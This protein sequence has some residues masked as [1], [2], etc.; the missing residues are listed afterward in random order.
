MWQKAQ[1]LSFLKS[2]P[3]LVGAASLLAGGVGAT[4][5]YRVAH[6]RL[7]EKFKNLA[8]T[9]I[10]DA[11][12][13]YSQLNRV[14]S[15]YKPPTPQE[16]LAERMQDEATSAHLN[17]QGISVEAPA[18]SEEEL[19]VEETTV[20]VEHNVFTTQAD[21]LPAADSGW[22]YEA[23][24]ARRNGKRP[25]VISKDEFFEN[26]RD[27]T[28]SQLTYY[29]GDDI[30]ADGT[31]E[32]IEDVERVVG[33]D[34]LRRFGHGSGS[35]HIVYIRNDVMEEIFEIALSDGKF[36]HEVLNFI[37]HSDRQPLRKFR[38]YDD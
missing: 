29:A 25:Y 23:E 12:A 1:V 2:T 24:R 6:N 27:Y 5:G 9:E 36:A 18:E 3:V 20:T 8:E 22:D 13:Y 38:G 33:E 10:E 31:D 30:L 34:N 15:E 7:E 28:E 14:V 35:E 37:E 11:K 26:E 16:A 4:A 32:P 17:Y 19:I 21:D